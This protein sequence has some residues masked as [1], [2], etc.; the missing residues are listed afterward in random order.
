MK[1]ITICLLIGLII[2]GCVQGQPLKFR[3]QKVS[4]ELFE[5][6]GAFDVNNDGKPDLVSGGY[7]YEGPRFVKKHLILQVKRYDEW[8]DDFSAI[9]MDVNGDGYLDVIS[10]GWWGNNV[11]WRENPGSKQ[12][13]KEWVEH[14]IGE[15][16]NV[17]TIRAWDIDGDGFPEIVPNNPGKA[18]KFYRLNRDKDGKGNG[19]F[20]EHILPQAK[21]GHGL[22]FG[23][24]NGD[25]RADLILSEG[26]LEAP[27]KQLTE[28]W[29][30]HTGLQLGAASIPILV[31][32]LNAD[33][34]ND[35]IVGQGHSY[36]LDW[37]EQMA[38]QTWKK[39][40][41]DPS[42]SQ[43][44]TM[45]WA[46]LYGNGKP[47]LVTGKRF[48]AHNDN[49]PGAHDDYGIYYYVWNGEGFT[50]QVVCYGPVVG[51]GAGIQIA[52]ADLNNDKRIDIAVAGK[53][54]L[55]IYFNE[56]IDP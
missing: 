12:N 2:A 23:D 55:H 30:W 45:E 31:Q 28:N 51:K 29:I 13:A 20:E 48:R 9:P 27:K 18:L 50:K 11:R 8:Y 46:D 1:K 53:D 44:H 5:A 49:D 21:Q 47:V 16:G 25:G 17:E 35:L 14:L 37:Y 10:G 3:V 34:K 38:N 4:N 24:I 41:I 7:W 42:N 56:G 52:I 19:T 54:G 6:V 22:G 15:T 39:H 40:P 43:F 36:G 33:G 26:W 32:D